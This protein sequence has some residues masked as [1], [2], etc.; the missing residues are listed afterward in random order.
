VITVLVAFA[1][2]K[3][4]VEEHI[5]V[6]QAVVTEAPPVEPTVTDIVVQIVASLQTSVFLSF[7]NPHAEDA[8][9]ISG[10]VT[11]FC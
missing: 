4:V 11:L 7:S 1:V 5:I 10:A 2:T 3:T 8:R 6:V 9:I